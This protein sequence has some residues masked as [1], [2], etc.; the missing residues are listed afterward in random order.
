VARRVYAGGHLL[1]MQ[2]GQGARA[3]RV[4]AGA[5]WLL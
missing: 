4:Y 3:R 2:R 5:A 1:Q